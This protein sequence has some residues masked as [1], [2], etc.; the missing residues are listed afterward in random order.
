MVRSSF[1]QGTN[2]RGVTSAPTFTALSAAL[3]RCCSTPSLHTLPTNGSKQHTNSFPQPLQE[4][5]GKRDNTVTKAFLRQHGNKS[6]SAASVVIVNSERHCPQS[7]H[8]GGS[9]G[10][11]ALALLSRSEQRGTE[12]AMEKKIR[13]ES[14]E[15]IHPR[16]DS[17]PQSLA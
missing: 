12:S 6:I 5:G 7:L 9:G 1:R 15:K 4:P 8:A 16:W 17:N 13:N 10:G 11:R 3:P 2:K 14:R